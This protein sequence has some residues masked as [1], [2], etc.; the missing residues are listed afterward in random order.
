MDRRIGLLWLAAA[1][2]LGLL[3]L[4]APAGAQQAGAVYTQCPGDTNGDSIPDGPAPAGL[5]LTGPV[6]CMH[7]SGGDGFVTMADGRPL[8]M[9]GFS[10]LTGTPASKAMDTGALAA[11]FPAPTIELDEGDN[12]FLNLTNVGM[13]LRPDLSDPH[14]VHFHGFPNAAPVFDGTPENSIA[15]NM[16][17]TLTYYYK[18]V[19]PGT[20]MYHCHVEAT[21]HMQMGMLGNLYVRPRQNRC[22]TPGNPACPP[23]G[24]ASGNTYAYND[25]DGSTRYDLEFPIQIGS[26]DPDFHDASENVQ[27]LPFASMKDRYAM[28]NGRGYPDT[29]NPGPI[30]TPTDRNCSGAGPCQPSQ[31]VS[32]LIEAAAGQRILLRISNLNVTRFYTLASTIPMK[33]VGHNARLHRGPSGTPLYYK[34]NS[35]TLGGG[36]S[37]DVLLETGGATGVEAGTY[38]LYTTNLNYLS[39]DGQDLGGMMTEIRITDGGV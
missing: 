22:G 14:S 2:T 32:S 12:F 37:V 35:V 31:P 19:E 5:H 9:F 18:L 36:E 1:L 38:L 3:A 8:Y 4:H 34:T 39:N 33:V 15:V 28:L 30:S 20:Y 26:F 23:G 29:V 21:E 17:S 11:N 7:L 24:A 27:P 13:T 25:G 10:D 16:G 6:K